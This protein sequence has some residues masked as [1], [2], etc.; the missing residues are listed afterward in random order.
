M[1]CPEVMRA[2]VVARTTPWIS[3]VNYCKSVLAFQ[4][5]SF[6]QVPFLCRDFTSICHFIHHEHI[7]LEVLQ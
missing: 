2:P 4:F 5:C 7:F 3:L 1:I 6:F